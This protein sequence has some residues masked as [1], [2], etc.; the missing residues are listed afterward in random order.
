MRLSSILISLLAIHAAAAETGS[1]RDDTPRA[2]RIDQKIEKM[3][4]EYQRHFKDTPV[5]SAREMIALQRDTKVLVVDVRTKGER[6]VSIIP[7][8]IPK[9]DFERDETRYKNKKIIVYCTIGYR[10]GLYAAKLRKKGLDAYNLKGGVLAW[11]SAGQL[12]TDQKGQTK[13]VHVYG[14]KWNLLPPDYEAVW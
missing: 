4:S 5:I 14:T 2:Q 3:F 6:Q 7:H 12:F 10:S 9:E 13:R 11:A 8:S 1:V